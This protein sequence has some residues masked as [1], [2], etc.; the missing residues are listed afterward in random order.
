MHAQIPWPQPTRARCS[1]CTGREIDC[2]VRSRQKNPGVEPGGGQPT[3]TVRQGG[4][5][6]WVGHGTVGR[7]D[8]RVPQGSQGG[9]LVR[10][11]RDAA[12]HTQRPLG[13]GRRRR[14]LP[15]WPAVGDG[16]ERQCGAG[17]ALRHG[18][19]AEFGAWAHRLDQR[20]RVVKRR[21][22]GRGGHEEHR[23]CAV[24]CVG[25]RTGEFS[26]ERVRGRA[27]LL[28][29]RGAAAGSWRGEGGAG[30]GPDPGYHGGGPRGPRRRRGDVS[31]VQLWGHARRHRLHRRHR[32]ALCGDRGQLPS[33]AS[34][35]FWPGVHRELLRLPQHRRRR[36]RRGGRGRRRVG[37]G[38]RRGRRGHGPEELQSPRG[39]QPRGGKDLVHSAVQR[40]VLPRQVQGYDRGRL[41]DRR[42]GGVGRHARRQARALGHCGPGALRRNEPD[43]FQGGVWCVCDGRCVRLGGARDGA[44]VEERA[45]REGHG[46]KRREATD[47]PPREQVRSAARPHRGLVGPLL[48]RAWVLGLALHLGKGRHERRRV[49]RAH[50]RP[51][52]GRGGRPSHHRD[53]ARDPSGPPLGAERM[54]C[55]TSQAPTTG[56]PQP[57]DAATFLA[58]VR[59]ARA[60]ASALPTLHSPAGPP[61]RISSS[62]QL[63]SG[64]VP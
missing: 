1:V 64:R 18:G 28:P 60:G 42:R 31:G 43:L 3:T 53:T 46:T 13:R 14:V 41:L 58:A 11:R 63:R 29:D 22:A 8:C 34:G 52:Q 36:H 40:G 15:G 25:W 2:I 7:Q 4:G 10:R 26:V 47:R 48:R 61:P 9:N 37:R 35:A 19:A 30:L 24:L 12:A 56:Q 50:P 62:P 38:G 44:A 5:G 6:A 16:G 57:L 17:V 27:G 45:R 51:H 59:P 21:Q 33:A 39:G 55:M 20:G 23:G 32:S 49:Q 54:L